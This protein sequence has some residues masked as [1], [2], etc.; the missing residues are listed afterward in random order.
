MNEN[1]IHRLSLDLELMNDMQE[2][3]VTKDVNELYQHCFQPA[4]EDVIERYGSQYS[5]LI[6]KID[7][8]LGTVEKKDIQ[9]LLSTRLEEEIKKRITKD[10]KHDIN[11]IQGDDDFGPDNYIDNEHIRR[12]F[13]D[14]THHDEKN[15]EGGMTEE[16]QILYYLR[17]NKIPWYIENEEFDVEKGMELFVRKV[18][19]N[20]SKMQDFFDIFRNDKFAFYRFI[21][22]VKPRDLFEIDKM[23]VSSGM[24][25]PNEITSFFK[26][27]CNIDE[28]IEFFC[29]SDE[30]HYILESNIDK[31]KDMLEDIILKGEN[32]VEEETLISKGNIREADSYEMAIRA[33]KSVL[34][35]LTACLF[36]YI[37]SSD[38]NI[39][40]M[41]QQMIHLIKTRYFESKRNDGST[42][43][44]EGDR[45]RRGREEKRETPWGKEAEKDVSVSS[46]NTR[47]TNEKLNSMEERRDIYDEGG[48]LI[49]E[50]DRNENI[51][52]N[53]EMKLRIEEAV[54]DIKESLE[55]KGKEAEDLIVTAREFNDTEENTKGKTQQVNIE[56]A[57][58]TIRESQEHKGKGA[59]DLIVTAREFDDTEENTK[60]KIQQANVNDLLNR[61]EER[62]QDEKQQITIQ[63]EEVESLSVEERLHIEDAGLVLLHP[64]LTAFFDT[65]KMLDSE[66]KQFVSISM[67]ER[68]CHLLK[69][70]TGYRGPHYGHLLT[71]EKMMCGL[72]FTYPI[73]KDFKIL[74]EEEQEINNLLSAV[75]QHW[76]PLKGSTT[77]SLQ[78]SFILRHGTLEYAD[79]AWIVRVEGSAI[80]I[81]LE[82]LPWEIST[83][84]F[85]WLEPMIFVEWQME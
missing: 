24:C 48:E 80:D 44:I 74:P 71:L 7:I 2:S 61:I 29:S 58:D 34:Q 56:E 13:Y 37:P 32:Q 10:K 35:L 14:F 16:E 67:Q 31:K 1:M 23:I 76:K 69:Y 59:E 55:H 68:A 60:E 12:K 19:Q 51:P 33:R 21:D 53:D 15:D 57:A 64:F 8:N 63:P 70:M 6:D 78:R 46:E 38:H 18:L 83:I 5:L 66:K 36:G 52:I 20:Q 84:L 45:I 3:Q 85:A 17:E 62:F 22:L 11:T 54:D 28:V 4:V 47:Q 50:K 26:K 72:P 75:C 39:L 65:L 81:L 27:I 77:E 43:M 30:E 40:L 49:S 42:Q 41:L 9:N 73:S 25:T 79:S 82:D